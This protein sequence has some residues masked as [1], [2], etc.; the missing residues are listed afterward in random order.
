MKDNEF[1]PDADRY[2]VW[3]QQNA[4]DLKAMFNIGQSRIDVV[5]PVQFDFLFE[6]RK[7]PAPDKKGYVMYAC[8]MGLSYY[9]EQEIEIV[10]NIRSIL[11]EV[12]PA[13]RL[14]V[15]PYPFRNSQSIYN[16]LSGR[17]GVDVAHFGK[18]RRA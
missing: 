4:D 3:N 18:F 15:R 7:K 12:A 17:E 14:L 13:T 8:S 2:L 5:G 9:I 6:N 10:L 11:D 1:I 16:K